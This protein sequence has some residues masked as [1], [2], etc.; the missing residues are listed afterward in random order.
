MWSSKN[1]VAVNPV[2][3]NLLTLQVTP[4]E[5]ANIFI[6][7]SEDSTFCLGTAVS[8]SAEIENGGIEPHYQWLVNGVQVYDHPDFASDSL[9]N[10]DVI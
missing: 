9:Q 4:N 1:C 10:G 8:F 2:Q 5:T 6:T 7:P 3:S